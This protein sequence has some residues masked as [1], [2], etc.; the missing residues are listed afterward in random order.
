MQTSV[1]RDQ[2]TGHNDPL[3][4]QLQGSESITQDSFLRNVD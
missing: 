3:E 2:F 4:D 1:L